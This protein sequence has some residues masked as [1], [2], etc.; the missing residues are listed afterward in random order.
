M[1]TEKK[2]TAIE[3][4]NDQKIEE[5]VS[6]YVLFARMFSIIARRVE[7]RL[8]DEGRKIMAQAVREFGE[9]RGKDIAR[10]ARNKGNENDLQ[11]YLVNYDMERSGLFGYENTYGE[12]E[13]RQVFDRCIFAE[14]W[15]EE[16]Q[17][18]YGR[19]YC[20]NIDPSIAH[21]YNER[22][23]CIHDKMMYDDHKCTFCFRMK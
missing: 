7:E 20:E 15:M 23:M 3:E 17:E 1:E 21:G 10:R 12:E 14:T 4:D 16:G 18:R 2:A 19:I 22:L 11:N 6:M 13:V 9:E 8:G 5:P